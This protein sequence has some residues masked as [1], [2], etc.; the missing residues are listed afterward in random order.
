MDIPIQDQRNMLRMHGLVSS[1][2]LAIGVSIIFGYLYVNVIYN[3]FG[4]DHWLDLRAYESVFNDPYY[5]YAQLNRS[6]ISWVRDEPLWY[7]AVLA[8]RSATWTYTETINFISIVSTIIISFVIFKLANNK[9]WPILFLINPSTIDLVIAQVRSAFALAV[10]MIA[11][12][13][14]PWWI[15]ILLLITAGTIHTSMYL[16]GVLYL[17]IMLYSKISNKYVFL[18]S[19]PILISSA[20]FIA[21]V[22]SFAAPVVLGAIGDRRVNIETDALGLLFSFTWLT[23]VVSYYAVGK[24]D[25]FLFPHFFYTICTLIGLFSIFSDAYGSRYI[26]VAIPFL[27]IMIARQE[28]KPRRWLLLQYTSIMLIYYYFYLWQAGVI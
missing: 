22:V 23:F 1:N 3:A 5:H 25:D 14:L 26:A 2:W 15:R 17:F 6:W 27:I 16:F 11:L 19:K 7:E 21:F 8:A 12:L 20:L 9:I 24:S 18:K 28:V 13:N 10:L 4:A